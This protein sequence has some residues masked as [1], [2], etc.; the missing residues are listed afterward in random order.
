MPT[1]T[2]FTNSAR[3]ARGSAG[4][5][6][7]AVL[8]LLGDADPLTVMDELPAA[9]DALLE[10]VSDAR[11]RAPEEPE[12]WSVL[13]VLWHLADSEV[14]YR[15]RLRR[16]VAQGDAIVGYDQDAWADRLHYADGDPAE[17]LALIRAL[18]PATMRWLRGLTPEEME[19]A[20]IHDE[21]G[22]ESVAHMVRLLAGHDLVHRNQIRRI[23]I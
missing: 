8:E 22:P 14:I 9:L 21:R 17:P 15:Y 12:K 4:A 10:G 16:A 11:L 23:L 5:Y 18:R 7:A 13:Q 1:V 19:R 6:T 2:V 20:G 3:S